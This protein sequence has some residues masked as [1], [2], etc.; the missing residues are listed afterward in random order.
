MTLPVLTFPAPSLHERSLEVSPEELT[1][2]KLQ[3]FIDDLIAT[4]IAQN[5]VGIAAPQVGKNIRIIVVQTAGGPEV[6]VN[7]QITARSFGHARG[8]EGCLS[9][10]GVFGLVERNAHVN[11]VALD[12]HGNKV[13]ANTDGFASIIFQHEIDHL[14]GI[15]FIDRAKKL[16]KNGTSKI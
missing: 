15:L 2:K 12:R 13:T 16:L 5:G 14:D 6:Y 8:E 3:S 11:V 10:P 4:M 9:V 1:Q 7:P